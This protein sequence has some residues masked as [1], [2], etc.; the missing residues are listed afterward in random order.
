MSLQR[1][2]GGADRLGGL[3]RFAVAISILNLLGHTWFGFEQAWAVPVVAL[4]A[5][6]A[7]ELT[8]EAIEAAIAG[9]R[10]RFRGGPRACIDFLLSAHISGLA[11]GMLL[12]T[13]ERLW[14][15]VFAACVAIGSKALI[16]IPAEDGTRHLM[17]PSNFGIA[18]TLLAFPWVGIAPPYQFTENLGAVGDWILP[19]IIVLTGSFMNWRF[20]RRLPL[21][22]AWLTTFVAQGAVRAAFGDGAFLEAFRPSLVPMTGLAFVLFTFYMVTDPATTPSQPRQQIVFGAGV[23]GFYGLL[24]SLHVV[25]GLFFALSLTSA[26]FG[27]ITVAAARIR[28]RIPA[29]EIVGGGLVERVS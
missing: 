1:V 4:A 28:R 26:A 19:G 20:T 16:R 29:G 3:R 8:L 22:A 5:A 21:I 13:N 27:V 18:V 7:T 23:A 10:P 11:V 25:F 6:Y 15:V 9:R 12:Y 17:N 14:P 2:W 24:V